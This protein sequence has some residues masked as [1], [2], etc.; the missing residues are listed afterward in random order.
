MQSDAEGRLFESEMAAK[1]RITVN[2]DDNEYK[3]LQRLAEEA[4]RSLAWLG[5][6]AIFELIEREERRELPL[7]EGQQ[8]SA[9][10]ERRAGQ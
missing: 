3:A 6:R 4:D 1:H 5:R 7:F 2:L 9:A 8:K 10:P